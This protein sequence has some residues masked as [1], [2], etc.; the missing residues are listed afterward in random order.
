LGHSASK[1]EHSASK[2]EQDPGFCHRPLDGSS[3]NVDRITPLI[4]TYNEAANI[5]RALDRLTWARRIVLV[6]SYSTDD[7]L[8]IASEYPQVDVFQRE[9]DHFAS[10]CNYGLEQIQT[11]WVLSLDADYVLSKELIAELERLPERRKVNGYTV[12]FVYCVFGEPLRAT[13]YPPRTVLYRRRQASYVEDGHAHRVRVEGSTESL[14]AKIYHDDRKSLDRWLTAQQ[15]YVDD[16]ID[17][18]RSARPEELSWPDRLRQRKWAPVLVFFY[19]LF[20]KGLVF[21]GKAGWYYT[22]QRTYA[23]LLLAIA[24]MDKDLRPE[25]GD[26]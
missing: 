15:S 21:D 9:F 4:L 26:D 5:G 3:V 16:E 6:D 17:K 13:L 14:D 20:G 7:T 25:A 24:L 19:C 12:S 18:Y 1:I 11:E 23:E 8:D 22:M 2:I 10:Q